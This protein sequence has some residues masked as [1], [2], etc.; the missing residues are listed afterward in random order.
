MT[1]REEATGSRI[2]DWGLRHR[3]PRQRIAFAGPGVGVGRFSLSQQLVTD[4]SVLMY[5]KTSPARSSACPRSLLLSAQALLFGGLLLAAAAPPAV[6]QDGPTANA[7]ERPEERSYVAIGVSGTDLGP[8]NNRLSANSYPTFSTELLS[9]GGGT[10]RVVAGR[11]LLGAELN[12]LL[13]PSQGFEGRDVFLGGG[14]GL[15]SLGY[16]IEPTPRL[17]AFPTA[18]VGAGGLLLN[19]GDDG[20]AHFDDVLADPNRSATLSTGSLLVSLRAGLEYQFG[21]PGG[22][23]LRLG[24][25]GG[26]LLSALSSDWQLGQSRLGGGPDASMQGPF[27]RLTVGGVRAALGDATGD[28]Q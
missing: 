3:S 18:G 20:S 25:R 5:W 26:Y 27:L 9:I 8:L 19:I 13:A 12:G 15:L 28:K 4:A 2:R 22:D 1:S 7:G 6:A 21:T 17:R 14:Y 24:L 23:G 10:Y 16:W 11:I